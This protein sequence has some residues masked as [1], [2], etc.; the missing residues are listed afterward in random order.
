ML[1]TL[2]AL[3]EDQLANYATD[4]ESE[5]TLALAVA[6]LLFEI[7]R[8][9]HDIDDRERTA[10]MHAV[11]KVCAVPEEDIDSLMATADQAAEE[12]VSVYDFTTVVNEHLARDKKYE[13]LVMLW[14]IAYADGRLD[15]YEEYY[16]RKIA[17]LLHLSH[18]DFIKAKHAAER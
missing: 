8:A 13:L 5:D 12:A 11:S 4:G 1:R 14:K 17:D 9:D 16:V 7:S 3:F 2:K 6:A 15:H 18:G 10:I